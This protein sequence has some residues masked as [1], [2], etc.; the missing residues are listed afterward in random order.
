M[1][2]SYAGQDLEVLDTQDQAA[3]A[4][5]IDAERRIRRKLSGGLERLSQFEG[6]LHNARQWAVRMEDHN[7]LME[8]GV[9]GAYREA[10]HYMGAGLVDAGL[11]EETDD[12]GHLSMAELRGDR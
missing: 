10:I 8:Q 1:I 7:H 2:G 5:R 11:T 9:A 3:R 4:G 6:E 12:V